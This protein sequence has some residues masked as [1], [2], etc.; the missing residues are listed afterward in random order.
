M[1]RVKVLQDFERYLYSP[2]DQNRRASHKCS[3][4]NM[5]SEGPVC[6]FL[7]FLSSSEIRGTLEECVFFYKPQLSLTRHYKVS[8]SVFTLKNGDSS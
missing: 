8:H 3:V 1:V 4:G 7:Y 5:L 2:E 6:R